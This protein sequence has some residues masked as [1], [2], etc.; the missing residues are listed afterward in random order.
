M[1]LAK[2]SFVAKMYTARIEAACPDT[3]AGAPPRVL[4]LDGVLSKAAAGRGV[5]AGAIQPGFSHLTLIF[6]S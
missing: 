3:A 2:K 1:K 4:S 6:G 5:A